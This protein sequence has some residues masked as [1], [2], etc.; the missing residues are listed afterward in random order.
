MCT[1]YFL[2]FIYIQVHPKLGNVI[3]EAFTYN[4]ILTVKMLVLGVSRRLLCYGTTFTIVYYLKYLLL[5][6]PQLPDWTLL[7]C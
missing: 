7:K 2:Q 3:T 6:W 1:L 4:S 5:Y